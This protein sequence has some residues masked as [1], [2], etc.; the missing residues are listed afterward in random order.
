MYCTTLLYLAGLMIKAVTED[1]DASDQAALGW[2]LVVCLFAGPVMVVVY[3]INEWAKARINGEKLKRK[4]AA[5]AHYRIE[6]SLNGPSL[7]RRK[8][9][10]LAKKITEGKVAA[11]ENT[12][13]E[14]MKMLA[15]LVKDYEERLKD[16]NVA[17]T[18][19]G[20]DAVKLS[21]KVRR[22]S[23]ESRTASP[24]GGARALKVSCGNTEIQ[25]LGS[26]IVPE[27]KLGSYMRRPSEAL[28]NTPERKISSLSRERSQALSVALE[29]KPDSRSSDKSRSSEA[30]SKTGDCSIAPSTQ[31]KNRRFGLR[32]RKKSEKRVFEV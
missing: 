30:G 3:E 1:A 13:S 31:S 16:A 25:S 7:A 20:G 6:K 5:A 10:D 27:R 19:L 24:A 32:T 12:N 15:K 11:R 26:S 21:T 17:I 23:Q 8:W 4:R 29:R 14:T 22:L 28:S 18:S 9:G 2:V